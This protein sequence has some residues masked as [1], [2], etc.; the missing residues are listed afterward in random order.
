[1]ETECGEEEKAGGN[2]NAV[3]VIP[4]CVGSLKIKP[5]TIVAMLKL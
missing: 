1:V 4:Q 3:E 2:Y 5:R